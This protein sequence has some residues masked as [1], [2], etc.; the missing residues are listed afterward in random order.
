[1]LRISNRTLFETQKPE[2]KQSHQILQLDHED[3]FPPQPVRVTF[4]IN[5]TKRNRAATEPTRNVSKASKLDRSQDIK[6]NLIINP[7]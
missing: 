2:L 3:Q 4:R 6:T 1:M 5:N 7:L